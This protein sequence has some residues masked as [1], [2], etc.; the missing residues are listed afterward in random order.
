MA[1]QKCPAGHFQPFTPLQSIRDSL[2]WLVPCFVA[3]SLLAFFASLINFFGLPFPQVAYYLEVFHEHF[4]N[5]LP[6]LI[7]VALSSRLCMDYDLPRPPV[8][9][10]A[11]VVLVVILAQLDL[12]FPDT[13]NFHGIFGFIVPF[14]TVPL[15]AFLYR[16]GFGRLVK[17]NITGIH[18][19]D[20]LNLIIPGF[21]VLL[22]TVGVLQVIY[23]L[24]ELLPLTIPALD[25]VE[26]PYSAG[27]LMVLLNSLF[28]F[29]GVHGYFAIT[30]LIEDLV[31]VESGL[32]SGG[33]SFFG[34][35]VF[36]GGVGATM[37]LVVAILLFSRSRLYRKLAI[38]SIPIALFN[39]NEV[40]LFC[41]PIILNYRL[42]VPFVALPMLNCAV[43][44]ALIQQEV[45][46]VHAGAMPINSPVLFNAWISTDGSLMGPIVQ[47][48]M[49]LVGVFL[50]LPFMVWND[51]RQVNAHVQ[52]EQLNATF[53]TRYED[54]YYLAGDPVTE[55]QA[56]R[57]RVEELIDRFRAIQNLS[58]KLFF[59]PKV[60]PV[61]GSVMGAEALIRAQDKEGRLVSPGSFLPT[62]HDGRMMKHI[63]QWVFLEVVEQIQEWRHAGHHL[64]PISVNL[65]A[66][67]LADEQVMKQIV[68]TV[69]PVAEF[70]RVE[71]TEEVLAKTDAVAKESLALLKAQR[72]AIDIDDFGTGYSS[73]SYI[74]RFRP[75]AVKLDRSFVL[76]LTE[77]H[78]IR[79]FDSV[80]EFAQSM[81][82][83]VIVEGVESEAELVHVRRHRG[84]LVQ[85]WCYSPALPPDGFQEFMEEY[86]NP[87]P[88][89]IE[90]LGT[91]SAGGAA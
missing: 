78:G 21:C 35:F 75:D 45:L 70:I 24:V 14:L 42:L 10:F 13:Y 9:L 39:I 17:S 60:D 80:I 38:I 18:V 79:L 7:G 77:S 89:R 5:L 30:P 76:N 12:Y 19:R 50:Y 63:D 87:K 84:L 74:S 27:L 55:S 43:G 6:F 83:A 53:S 20:S 86:L 40:L 26:E 15:M 48:L 57:A 64:V 1:P 62:F 37:S 82:L 71:I 3:S 59:Q 16:R 81:G 32:L 54:I 72:I 73:L 52:L 69:Q 56:Q 65:D 67:T 41:L 2:L 33:L 11:L 4:Y 68:K 8:A 25:M 22:T 47:V 90:R 36:I 49:V 44:L 61:R 23:L 46:T 85:G 58:F 91:A 88:E 66:E 28:W 34:S 51:R 29:I 31:A